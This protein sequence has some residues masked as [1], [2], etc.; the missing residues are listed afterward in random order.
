MGWSA[1]H[2]VTLTGRQ[3]QWRAAPAS[4]ALRR[5]A[6]GFDFDDSTWQDIATPGHWRN[7]PGLADSDGP[8]L[9]RHHFTTTPPTADG[10]RQFVVLDGVFYQADVWL[11]GAYLG[12]PEGYFFPHSFDVTPLLGMGDQHVLAVEVSCAPQRDKRTKRNL[13]GVFQH[14][15]AM[16]D[17]WNPGG[18]WRDVRIEHTGPVRIETFTVVC[19]DANESRAHVLLNT[20]LDTAQSRT[21][22]LKTRVDGTV[23]HERQQSL[24]RGLND[25]VWS[26]DIPRPRLWW[27]YELG[28]QALTDISCE[29]WVDGVL[30]HSVTRR[31]GLRE[32]ALGEW[33]FSVN[34]ERLFV[35]GTNHAPTRQSLADA[36]TEELR[37]DVELARDL[38]LNM[39][40]V[41]AHVTRPEF[42]EAADALGMLVWQDMPL[43][44]G[45]ARSV[46]R[47]AVRQ[48][49]AL[50][51][52]LGH[53]PSIAVWCGHNEPLALRI[54]HATTTN[55]PK[56]AAAYLAGQQLPTWNKTI[57]DRWIK[58][59]LEKAD[60]SR[61]VIAHSG[62]LPHLPQIEGTDSHLYFGWYHGHERD[63][64][65]FARR[66]PRM[67]RFVSEFGAQSVPDHLP[68]FDTS[69]WPNLDWETVA[70]RFGLQKAMF[71]KHVPVDAFDTFEEWR[72]ATQTYQAQ[73][74]F[75]H[76]RELRRLKYSPTGGF[77]FFSF[78]DPAPR[79]SWS[80]LD[81][82]RTPKLAWHAVKEA[83]APVIVV[84]DRI[85]DDAQA[86]DTLT[87]D[88]H[89]VND[90]RRSLEDAKVTVTVE[91]GD[92]SV[93]RTWAGDI[94][95]DD[96][97]YV[98]A[99]EFDLPVT[100]ESPRVTGWI[101]Y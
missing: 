85:P 5:D 18:L 61:P 1:E 9:Y 13:T 55:I 36:T 39:M 45:Y 19:R 80:V 38:G 77:M 84:V 10:T 82:H 3:R 60:D 25:V 26:F 83:C 51:R 69:Q 21:V 37:R 47:Q 97:C 78:A 28:E 59:T 44:W 42:Y 12:D 90:L 72:D 79:I 33:T 8:I 95:H 98:G 70:A 100:R 53:H 20:Q 2:D 76:I 11:D 34:G 54:D 99:V 4:E 65:D 89:V 29:V 43:Q 27:P 35:K 17:T 22:S 73:L 57:L 16:D 68:D 92:W 6:M 96:V 49:H 64:P 93:S 41:H 74:L 58:T 23:L 40:R 88:V 81:H 94:P 75:H 14:W 24:A 32:V 67:V 63:L 46:R 71:D 87:L 50:V 66:I 91:S 86:G 31:T 15:D 30:S 48:A 62:V 52:H 56:V 101:N 7:A